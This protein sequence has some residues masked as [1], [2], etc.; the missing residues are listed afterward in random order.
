MGEIVFI[1]F[2]LWWVLR[3]NQRI[4]CFEIPNIHLKK[5]RKIKKSKFFFP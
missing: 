1:L 4:E 5:K 2:I 3:I